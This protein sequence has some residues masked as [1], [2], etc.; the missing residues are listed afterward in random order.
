MKPN[1]FVCSWSQLWGLPSISDETKRGKM[2]E[3]VEVLKNMVYVGV[4][5]YGR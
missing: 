4:D 5:V 1:L 3:M 2:M